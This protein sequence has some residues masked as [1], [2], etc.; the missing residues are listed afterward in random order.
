MIGPARVFTIPFGAPFLPTLAEAILSGH[1]VPGW[2]EAGDPLSLSAGTVFVPTRRAARALSGELAARHVGP[3]VLLPRV[4]PL[5]DV[6]DAEETALF[7]GGLS[8]VDGSALAPAVSDTER[9]LTLAALTLAW[10][11][12]VDRSLLKLDAGEALLVPASPA[13]ALALAGDLGRLIDSLAIH[14]KSVAEIEALVPDEYDEYWRITRDFLAIAVRHWPSYCAERG[15][16]DAAARRHELI[17]A[18]AK[19]LTR[20]P[21]EGPI[22]AAGSTGSMPATAALLGAIA[23]L[24]RGALVL[25]GLDPFLDDAAWQD[26]AGDAALRVQGQPTHPQAL[27]AALLARLGVAR[28]EVETLGRETPALAARSALVSEALRPAESTDAWASRAERLP[29]SAVAAALADV[30]VIEAQDEREQALAIA[31]VLREALEEPGRTAALVTPDRGLAER[32]GA[33]LR[34][35]NVDVDDSAGTPLARAPYGVFAT[36]VAEVAIQDFEPHRLLALLG[37]P[38]TRLGLTRASVLRARSTLEI[39]VWRG[40]APA[41]GLEPLAQALAAQEGTVQRMSRPRRRLKRADFA[42]AADLIARLQ[43]AFAPLI[44][45]AKAPGAEMASLISA[46]LAALEAIAAPAQDEPDRRLAGPDGEALAALFDEL[47][48]TPARALTGTGVDYLGF[49]AGL[50]A[51]RSVAGMGAGHRRVKIWGLLEARLLSADTV[52]LGGLNEKTWPPETRTDAFLNRPMR[53]GLGLPAP[54]RRIGQTAHDF[55]AALG[56]PKVVLARSAKSGGNPTVASRFLRRL[57]AISSSSAWEGAV[58]RGEQ[59]L[60]WTQA[61]E[62]PDTVRRIAAPR[63]RP[64]PALIP[65]RISVTEVETLVRDPY[66]IFARHVLEL[67]RLDPI[68]GVPGAA[69]RGTLIHDILGEFARRY[70]AALPQRP[71]QTLV[72]L[73]GEAFGRFADNVDVKAFWWPR[74]LRIAAFIAGFEAERRPLIREVAA[75]RDGALE[76][77][78]AC[79]E[80]IQLRARADRIEWRTDGGFAIVDYKTGK[81]PSAPE[82]QAGFAPQ[83]TLE[84]A[85]MLSGAFE[86]LP[87]GLRLDELLHVRLSG[88]PTGGEPVPVV[89]KTKP[90]DQTRLAHD[91]LAKLTEM[92]NAY[93]GLGRPFLSRPYPQ[94]ARSYAPYD[95]LARVREWSLGSDEDGGEGEP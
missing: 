64:D 56:A 22:I 7:D 67:D 55:C 24:P 29:D 11:R 10:A 18:E 39:G 81:T 69:D 13:D 48:A 61:L 12:A 42:E 60:A 79:G 6:D 27:L 5:G 63:P 58:A 31:L 41:P 77:A 62:K 73:G 36:L 26:V 90:V 70:P 30:A 66:A 91:H 32:V 3:A 88:G 76:I 94:F 14:G 46:H 40:G 21:P 78:L 34:R 25:P 68:G 52:V 15:V 72:A 17:L 87:G 23:R 9:R 92:M 54:E 65:R 82:V 35:W 45:A 19:R 37:H 80:T 28:S 59:V 75:E 53:A 8:G 71:Y 2:P 83:L 44:A 93:I 49:F 38:L 74:F 84:G 95:H 50:L 57:K 1:L 85:M 86:G 4:V 47:A 89:N 16:M 20:D 43:D 33:E 51:G